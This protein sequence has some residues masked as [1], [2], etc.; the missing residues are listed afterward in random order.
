M[1]IIV[2]FV[3]GDKV[4]I[5]SDSYLTT[6]NGLTI[7]N[8]QKIFTKEFYNEHTDKLNKCTFGMSGTYGNI[9]A[10]KHMEFPNFPEHGTN[11][12]WLLILLKCI[13]DVQIVDDWEMIITIGGKLYE[14][15]SSCIL[16]KNMC[17]I[18]DGNHVGLGSLYTSTGDGIDRVKKAIEVASILCT[19]VGGPIQIFNTN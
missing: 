8:V 13:R 16:E 14:C 5:G 18:G 4:I 3:D 6:Q 11:E 10:V 1:T 17:A 12:K 9:I 7:N 19:S 15:D 2:G